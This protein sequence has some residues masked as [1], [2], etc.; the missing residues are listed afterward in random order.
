M[1]KSR[2]IAAAQ[3]HTE[4]WGWFVG[5]YGIP[6]HGFILVGDPGGL[7]GYE[8]ARA[9]TVDAALKHYGREV[10][11]GQGPTY[12]TATQALGKRYAFEDGCDH[13][14]IHPDTEHPPCVACGRTK[15]LFTLHGIFVGTKP[16]RLCSP[17]NS[18]AARLGLIEAFPHLAQRFGPLPG[19]IRPMGRTFKDGVWTWHS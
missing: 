11:M 2:L 13:P 6:G 3:A 16:G 18:R 7:R 12:R 5:A 19:V 9:D 15:T 4:A 8:L 14:E 1:R 10:L 17:C